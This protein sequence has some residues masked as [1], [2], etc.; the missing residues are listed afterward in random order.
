VDAR[1]TNR[2]LVVESFGRSA[3]FAPLRIGALVKASRTLIPEEHN[4]DLE[5][6]LSDLSLYHKEQGY[7]SV[8]VSEGVKIH[9]SFARNAD[10]LEQAFAKDPVAKIAFHNV[11]ALDSFGHPKLENAGLIVA[12]VLKSGLKASISLAGKLD[13]LVRSAPISETDRMMCELV[14]QAGIE[15]LVRGERDVLLYVANGKVES[16]KLTPNLGG[17]A[18]DINGKDKEEFLTA[19]QALKVS[20]VLVERPSFILSDEKALAS[21]SSLYSDLYR[22]W[23]F[24]TSLLN[25]PKDLKIARSNKMDFPMAYAGSYYLLLAALGVSRE[26]FA[27]IGLDKVLWSFFAYSGYTRFPLVYYQYWKFSSVPVSLAAIEETINN[28]EDAFPL[29]ESCHK[30][31]IQSSLKSLEQYIKELKMNDEKKA[32][33]RT[34][35]INIE[36]QY[37]RAYVAERKSSTFSEPKFIINNIFNKNEEAIASYANGL[38][39]VLGYSTN[40]KTNR[41]ATLRL[42][43]T[44]FQLM[45]SLVDARE[46]FLI[47]RPN[48]FVS[49]ARYHFPQEFEVFSQQIYLKRI[50]SPFALK[51]L[52]PQTYRTWGATESNYQ[53]QLRQNSFFI[54]WPLI[55]AFKAYNLLH[56]RELHKIAKN[57]EGE[58]SLDAQILKAIE[59]SP[60]KQIPLRKVF[61]IILY[62]TNGYHNQTYLFK[63]D[64]SHRK[65]EASAQGIGSHPMALS[66]YYGRS[67]EEKLYQ[68]WNEMDKPSVFHLVDVR[69]AGTGMLLR[70]IIAQAYEKHPEFCQ[71]LKPI[72]IS[73]TDD[74]MAVHTFFLDSKKNQY[75]PSYP[76]VIFIKSNLSKDGFNLRIPLKDNSVQG[77][78]LNYEVTERLIPVLLATADQGKTFQE[79]YVRAQDNGL[80]ET[81]GKIDSNADEVQQYLN[82]SKR[83]KKLLKENV[84]GTSIL[85]NAN[86]AYDTWQKEMNRILTNG[87][88]WT[89]G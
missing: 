64:W 22:S 39:K 17:R 43:Q 30:S 6:L 68:M 7:A 31:S 40:G 87:Y 24:Y 37:L 47:D 77:V 9:Q 38:A 63:G 2:I 86:I 44:W 23:N 50:V 73:Y 65:P 28:P 3:G 49:L 8:V 71:A 34:L 19:N 36:K 51:T 12:A 14:G 70:D 83:S 46:D 20:S 78:I 72:V 26:S 54:I 10:I 41:E 88:I 89:V 27:A 55:L 33:L 58:P 66:P 4:L 74:D 60:E 52:M 29:F 11:T 15:R 25:Y 48:Y 32:A 80:V 85:I 84:N 53:K 57:K 67:L 35:L 13:Y 59:E 21:S 45:D 61:E 16:L 42:F 81:L 5:K 82:T 56:A 18:V 75:P 69:G 76:Q 79:R 62:G 1:S